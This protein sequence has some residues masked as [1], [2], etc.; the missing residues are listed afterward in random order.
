MKAEIKSKLAWLWQF[1]VVSLLRD[2][3]GDISEKIVGIVVGLL[4]LGSLAPTAVIMASNST[5]YTGA[6]TT[7]ITMFATIVPLLA[8]IAVVY[9]FLKGRRR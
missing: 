3:Q 5:A 6:D 1:F 4:I 2:V 7:V 9:V 8:G